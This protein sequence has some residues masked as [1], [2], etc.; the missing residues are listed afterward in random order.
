[1]NDLNKVVDHLVEL[2]NMWDPFVLLAQESMWDSF[3][4]LQMSKSQPL[5]LQW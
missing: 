3:A 2:V 1:M 5:A 4:I